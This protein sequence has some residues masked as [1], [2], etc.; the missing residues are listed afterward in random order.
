MA[1]TWITQLVARLPSLT[2]MPE[3]TCENVFHVGHET[4]PTALQIELCV[5]AVVEFYTVAAAGAVQDVGF[6]LNDVLDRT[7]DASSV[8]AYKTDDL[9]GATPF[10]SPVDQLSFTLGA[11]A[12]G[13]PFPEE[14]ACVVSYNGDLTNV[15]VSQANPSPPPATIRP[16]Q[17]RR[18]RTFIGPLSA[19]TGVEVSGRIRPTDQFR[20]DTLTNFKALAD[21][22]N[23]LLNCE[24]G[25][26]S[27]AD[28][29]FY[30][31][32][33]AY[34][35]DAWDTQRR[36]GPDPTDRQTRTIT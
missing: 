25:V 9:S 22:I 33:A 10:G 8:L 18:G 16:A 1:F 12:S 20:D 27:K 32:V 6:Y 29:D 4:E 11:Q 24:F 36:R 7:T 15:A 2:G 14:V 31:A 30:R 21:A 34:M 35:D 28:A 26:W 23:A 13:A 5:E 3:D 19:I 17:R